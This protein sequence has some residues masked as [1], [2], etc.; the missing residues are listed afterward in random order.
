MKDDEENKLLSASFIKSPVLA[1]SIALLV[2]IIGIISFIYSDGFVTL[3]NN[4]INFITPS[5]SLD[6]EY[7]TSFIPADGQSQL[8]VNIVA[9]N[10]KDQLIDGEEIK[11]NVIEGEIAWHVSNNPPADIS[12]QIIIT[13]STKPTKATINFSLNGK[14]KIFNLEIFDTT[15]PPAPILSAPKENNKFSTAIPIVSGQTPVGT[16]VEIYV[17][18][19]L[20]TIS[21]TDESG[22]FS[23]PLEKPIG[24]GSH[25]IYVVA[26]NKYNIRSNPSNS[27]NINIETPDPEIDLTNIRI[28]P[29]PIKSNEVFYIFIPTSADTQKVS[30]ILEDTKWQLEDKHDSSI[31]SGTIKSPKKPGLYRLSTI[32]TNASGDSILVNNI[33]SIIVE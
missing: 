21:D 20:N 13:S 22:L 32:I 14:N 28:K 5:F 23:L 17:D 10:K 31:F 27:V 8:P 4:W 15:P 26:V 25:A 29:N 7:D 33:T 11:I 9:K 19:D 16:K 6:I 12:K 1:F 2:I 18:T 24:N 30:I 3:K